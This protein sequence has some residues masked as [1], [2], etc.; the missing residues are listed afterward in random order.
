MCCGSAAKGLLFVMDL[1]RPL[2]RCFF[3]SRGPLDLG[4]ESDQWNSLTVGF[5]H[6]VVVTDAALVECE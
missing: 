4:L 3:G 1:T 5:C 6:V 2:V